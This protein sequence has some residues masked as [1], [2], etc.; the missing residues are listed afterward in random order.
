[1]V[2]IDQQNLI[3]GGTGSFLVAQFCEAHSEGQQRVQV[4]RILLDQVV[5]AV[6]GVE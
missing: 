4:V 6:G 2:G 5:V 3:E 1:M